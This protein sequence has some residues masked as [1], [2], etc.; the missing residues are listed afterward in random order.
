MASENSALTETSEI[1]EQIV[2]YLDGELDTEEVA[3][4]E[5]RLADDPAYRA[6]LAQLERAWD[7]LD[8]LQRTE[9]DDDFV[10]STVAMVAV[11]A[12]QEAKTQALRVARRRN[13]TAAALAAVVLLTGALTYGIVHRRVTRENRQ[14]VRD[15]PVI[16]RVDE[17]KYIDR[18]EFLKQLERENLFAAE[19]VDE[20]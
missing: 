9:A 16:E 4:V 1:D 8:T 11:Q 15:L 10:N 3:R 5:R 13:L 20:M 6:R 19:V 7:M 17:Y 14:L 18:L 12:E 2:A